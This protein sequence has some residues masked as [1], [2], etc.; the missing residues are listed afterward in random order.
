MKIGILNGNVDDVIQ[1]LVRAILRSS[2]HL[3]EAFTPVKNYWNPV[4]TFLCWIPAATFSLL[5]SSSYISTLYWVPVATPQLCWVPAN[6]FSHHADT[7]Y[8]PQDFPPPE[9]NQLHLTIRW[10]K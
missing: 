2:L 9:Q 10:N 6:T 8:R 1:S 7:C 3:R 4:A 5:D